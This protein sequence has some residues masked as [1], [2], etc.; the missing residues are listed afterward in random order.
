MFVCARLVFGTAGSTHER[1][2]PHP[3][4]FLVRDPRIGKSNG[5]KSLKLHPYPGTLGRTWGTRPLCN[6]LAVLALIALRIC[7]SASSLQY[8]QLSCRKTEV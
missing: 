4:D 5:N 1:R 6:Y 7:A 8:L 2:V 3:P